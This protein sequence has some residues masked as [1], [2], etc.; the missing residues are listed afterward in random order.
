[1]YTY[2]VQSLKLQGVQVPAEIEAY[3]PEQ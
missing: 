2:R 3:R 1:V